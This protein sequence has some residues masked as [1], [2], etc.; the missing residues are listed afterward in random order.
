[1]SLYQSTQEWPVQSNVHVENRIDYDQKYIIRKYNSGLL[2][3]DSK[4]DKLHIT[5]KLFH[6]SMVI[7]IRYYARTACLHVCPGVLCDKLVAH[8]Y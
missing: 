7:C 2:I 8:N 6:C 5:Q 3:L 4:F 1:M